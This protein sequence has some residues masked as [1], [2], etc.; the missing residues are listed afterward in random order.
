M[1]ELSEFGD[2]G[3]GVEGVMSS[4]K[5]RT[6]EGEAVGRESGISAS[7]TVVTQLQCVCVCVCVCVRTHDN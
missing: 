6:V 5:H 1:E 2:S 7:G 3:E 4:I